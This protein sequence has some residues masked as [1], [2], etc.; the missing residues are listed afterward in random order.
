MNKKKGFL[1][2][3]IIVAS[4]I[5]MMIIVL[6]A[7]ITKIYYKNFLKLK[8]KSNTKETSI[9]LSEI[10]NS[11]FSTTIETENREL[12]KIKNQGIGIF[13]FKDKRLGNITTYIK[14]NSVEFGEKGD[15][16]YIEIPLLKIDTNGQIQLSNEYYIFRFYKKNSQ[17]GKVNIELR[18]IRA[19]DNGWNNS[20]NRNNIYKF[21]VEETLITGI[22]NGSFY[23]V[24]GGVVVEFDDRGNKEYKDIFLRCVN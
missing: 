9:I 4:L 20:G 22:K 7:P 6:I 24:K 16:L 18:Y 8:E 10:S 5:T 2:M 21:G 11:I 1:T 3:E 15:S 13:N 23:E 12:L 19:R 17:N 14:N